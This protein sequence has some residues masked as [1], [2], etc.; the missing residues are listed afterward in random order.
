M[1]ARSTRI[2][3]FLSLFAI[4]CLALV[5]VHYDEGTS[6]ERAPLDRMVICSDCFID[7]LRIVGH[8]SILVIKNPR[9]VGPALAKPG[10]KVIVC[11]QSWFR[12]DVFLAQKE[13]GATPGGSNWAAI[14]PC[15]A[16]IYVKQQDGSF[17]KVD[18]MQISIIQI[19][20]TGADP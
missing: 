6:F 3:L 4:T 17:E 19:S 18:S 1:I 11:D 10:S 15:R 20:E 16:S 8:S 13:T 9:T 7:P 12:M 14:L 2:R 5:W